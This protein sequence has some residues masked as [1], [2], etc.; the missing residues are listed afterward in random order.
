MAEREWMQVKGHR[1]G[2][3]LGW[4][5]RDVLEGMGID[6]SQATTWFTREQSEAIHAHR[7]FE[8][9]VSEEPTP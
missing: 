1:S 6:C 5:P 9:A 7:E 4:I 2:K 8:R 3:E